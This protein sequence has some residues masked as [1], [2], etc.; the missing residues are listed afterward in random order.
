MFGIG[1]TEMIM[2]LALALI[3][4]GPK[5]L[6]DIARALGRGYSEFRRA[7]D[8]L[9][10][11]INAEVTQANK[12][13]ARPEPRDFPQDKIYPPGMGVNPYPPTTSTDEPPKPSVFS[14]E[15]PEHDTTEPDET[16]ATD[17]DEETKPDVG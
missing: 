3:V 8:E 17:R 5:R 13:T 10:N 2:I 6:P 16:A 4:I 12:K 15:P 9:K 1:M 11:S 7:T 14:P